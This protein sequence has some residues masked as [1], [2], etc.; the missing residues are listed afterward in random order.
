MDKIDKTLQKI[1]KKQR[2]KILATMQH[3]RAGNFTGLD[4]KKLQGKENEY[5]VRE[6]KVRIKFSI[7]NGIGIIFAVQRRSE[8][9]YWI[10]LIIT[11]SSRMK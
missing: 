3:I 5:R 6:G 1:A 4:M 8:T 9:T 7:I 11:S 2:I 10:C